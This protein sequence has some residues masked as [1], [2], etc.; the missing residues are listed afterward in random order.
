VAGTWRARRVIQAAVWLT[1]QPA[2]ASGAFL[3][4]PTVSMSLSAT[5]RAR[6]SLLCSTYLPRVVSIRCIDTSRAQVI[7]SQ[8]RIESS[9]HDRCAPEL[10]QQ[11]GSRQQEQPP[12]EAEQPEPQP[13]LLLLEPAV[14]QHLP[15]LEPQ[16]AAHADVVAAGGDAAEQALLSAPFPPS[17][18]LDQHRRD[19]PREISAKTARAK[20]TMETARSPSSGP[21]R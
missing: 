8:S 6:V 10:V 7:L 14:V 4:G 5:E 15:L 9:G 16:P 21:R 20:Q 13:R 2:L 19:I 12:L 1:W 17:T 3:S 18:L 11:V